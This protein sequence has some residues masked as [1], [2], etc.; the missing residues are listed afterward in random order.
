MAGEKLIERIP[1]DCAAL[2]CDAFELSHA[3]SEAMAQVKAPGH[4]TVK[5]DPLASREILHRNGFYYCDTLIEPYCAAGQLKRLP[6]PA[7]GFLVQP[8]LDSL[9]PICRGAAWRGRFHRD[10]NVERRLADL[11]YE[12]W[13]CTLHATGKVFG[14]T[15]E[16]EI[17]GFVA[18]ERG[19][20]IL[21]ALGEEHR[22][23]GIAKHL[24]S[25]ICEELVFRGAETLS[26]SISVANAPALSLYASLGFRFRNSVDIYHRVIR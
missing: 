25:A 11:R 21:H 26:S 5:V 14:L 24:W 22:G 12:N 2:G 6:H 19:K 16:N 4:Y 13:L 10:F 18:H 23:R 15:W 7:A 8:A 17:A 3:G 9:L 20:L 1:W